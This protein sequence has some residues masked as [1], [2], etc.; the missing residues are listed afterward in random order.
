VLTPLQEEE[1][2]EEDDEPAPLD[3]GRGVTAIDNMRGLEASL[4]AFQWPADLA[5]ADTLVTRVRAKRHRGPAENAHAVRSCAAVLVAVAVLE[6]CATATSRR[7]PAWR[8]LL[9]V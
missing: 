2:M 9:R 8:A 3:E 1:E 4:S 5:W 7:E 6:A